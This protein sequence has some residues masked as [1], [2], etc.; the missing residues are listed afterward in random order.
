MEKFQ[1]KFDEA[2][3]GWPEKID[4]SDGQLLGDNAFFSGNLWKLHLE[5]EDKLPEEDV[6][7]DMMSWSIYNVLHKKAIESVKNGI[8]ILEPI[9]VDI[10]EY[11]E[12]FYENLKDAEDCYKEISKDN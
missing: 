7:L 6:W 8:Y 4:I 9:K 2:I 5:I 3:K 1:E 12:C 10:E 11:R